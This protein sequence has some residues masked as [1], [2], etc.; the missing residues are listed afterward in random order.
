M[1]TFDTLVT[2]LLALELERLGIQ[3]AL[4]LAPF[5]HY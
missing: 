3:Y 1:V 5:V 4:P 2:I